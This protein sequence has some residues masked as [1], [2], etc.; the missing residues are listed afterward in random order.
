MKWIFYLTFKKDLIINEFYKKRK[1]K[2]YDNEIY[3]LFFEDVNFEDNESIIN[4]EKNLIALPKESK[5]NEADSNDKNTKEENFF[6]SLDESSFCLIIK[7]LIIFYY[8]IKF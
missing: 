6:S 3:G 2:R 7:L 1:S 8:I 5:L 4:I